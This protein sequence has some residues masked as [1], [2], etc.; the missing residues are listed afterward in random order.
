MSNQ[1]N[2]GKFRGGAVWH[3]E[4]N[5]KTWWTPFQF[6]HSVAIT[7]KELEKMALSILR[8]LCDEGQD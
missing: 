1:L 2:A 5:G 8:D 6:S 4:D 7:K 3:S